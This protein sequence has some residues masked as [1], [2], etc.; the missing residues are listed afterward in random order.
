MPGNM[1]KR[2]VSF[3]LIMVL[4]TGICCTA[5]TRDSGSAREQLEK[6]AQELGEQYGYMSLGTEHFYAGNNMMD[7]VFPEEIAEHEEGILFSDLY[8]YDND[9]TPELLVFRRQKGYVNFE[10]QGGFVSGLERSEYLFEMYEYFEEGYCRVSSRFVVG[11]VDL[12]NL[13]TSHTSMTVF[14]RELDGRTELFM[15]TT[16]SGQDHP[17]DFCLVRIR[18]ENGKFC[19][20]SGI[21]YGALFF[22]GNNVRCME[23]KSIEAFETL[24]YS[25]SAD[26]RLWELKASADSYDESVRNALKESL[27]KYGLTLI[28]VRNDVDAKEAEE[29]SALECYGTENGSLTPL[30]FTYLHRAPAENKEGYTSLKLSRS[31]NTADPDGADRPSLGS[32]Q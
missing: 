3:L 13:F 9:G 25:G 30:A 32:R 14:R 10:H 7:I 16:M 31:I 4:M 6:K 2:F 20:F 23:S 26:E 29:Y 22:G 19:D 5:E 12:F 17:E 24:S 1:V 11:A 27:E 28:T 8:D 15:E 18:Y 21:R